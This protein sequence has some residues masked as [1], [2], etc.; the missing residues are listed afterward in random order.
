MENRARSPQ[1]WRYYE[2]VASTPTRLDNQTTPSIQDDMKKVVEEVLERKK[3]IPAAKEQQRRKCP[4]TT[5]ILEKPLPR[6]F[7]MPQITSYSGKDDPYDHIQ[8]YESL[9]T[10]HEW[11]DDIM[12]R[13]FSLTLS[14]HA[15]IWFNSLPEASISSVGQFRTKFIKAFVINSQRKKNA[16]YSI[17]DRGRKKL[18]ISMWIDFETPP[19]CTLTL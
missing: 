11:D 2:N 6:K 13:A 12:C 4:F 9:M 15:R 3:L 19:G 10:L 17:F 14:G 5:N 7:K 1:R 8:N 18:C 16:T